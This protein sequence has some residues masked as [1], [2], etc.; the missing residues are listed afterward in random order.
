M[1]MMAT[2]ER[3]YTKPGCG[4]EDPRPAQGRTQAADRRKNLAGDSQTCVPQLAI[5]TVPMQ[6]WEE[7]YQPSQALLCGTIFPSLNKPF[8]KTGGEFR[9]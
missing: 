7:P 5:A 3:E 6:Q 2:Y 1:S 8:Y 9:G 4:C